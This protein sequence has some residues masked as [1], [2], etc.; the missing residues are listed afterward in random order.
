A[1][2]R[3]ENNLILE[4]GAGGK[5]PALSFR[6]ARARPALGWLLHKANRNSAECSRSSAAAGR[7]DRWRLRI[8]RGTAAACR[9]DS[10]PCELGI[11]EGRVER[12]L[13]DDHPV[14]VASRRSPGLDQ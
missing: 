5:L 9:R 13:F 3:R 8:D 6:A 7:V 12:D 10:R 14:R 11:I 1:W 4:R 2:R